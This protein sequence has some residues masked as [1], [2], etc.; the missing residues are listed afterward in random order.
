MRVAGSLPVSAHSGA[1]GLCSGAAEKL[2]DL[3]DA[4]PN[5]PSIPDF[6]DLKQDC[7]CMPCMYRDSG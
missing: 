4:L 1:S 2:S 3:Q 5:H 6:A 7:A